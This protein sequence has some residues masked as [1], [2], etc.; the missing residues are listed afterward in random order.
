MEFEESESSLF[1]TAIEAIDKKD[2]DRARD[3]FTRLIKMNPEKADYWVWMSSLVPSVKEKTYCLQE[4]LRLD[5]RNSAARRGLA[6]LGVLSPDEKKIIPLKAQKRNWS[7]LYPSP[8]FFEKILLI[9]NWVQITVISVLGGSLLLFLLVFYL[10]TPGLGMPVKA[11]MI[12]RPVETQ[13]PTSYSDVSSLVSLNPEKTP[14]FLGPTPFSDLLIVTYTPTPIYVNTPHPKHEGYRSAINAFNK[15]DLDAAIDYLLQAIDA[16]PDSPDLYYHLGE[17][18]RLKKDY[19]NAINAYKKALTIDADFAPAYLGRG[20]ATLDGY[21]VKWKDAKADLIKATDLDSNLVEGYLKTAEI[22]LT[23][24]LDP[25]TAIKLIDKAHHSNPNDPQVYI[26][27]AKVYLIQNQPQK[28]LEEARVAF[29]LDISQLEAYHLVAEAAVKMDQPALALEELIFYCIYRPDDAEALYWLGLAY[30]QKG[31]LE[32][33]VA[34]YSKSIKTDPSLISTFLK[35][36]QIY[37]DQGQFRLARTD[38]EK[39]LSLDK[40]SYD[41]N[42]NMARVLLE[43]GEILAAYAK[44]NSADDLSVNNTQK[45]QIYYWRAKTL[46]KMEIDKPSYK[47]NEARDWLALLNQPP[48]TVPAEWVVEAQNRVQAIK[49]YTPLQ[50]TPVGVPEPVNTNVGVSNSGNR[51]SALPTAYQPVL[52]P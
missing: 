29:K 30:Q 6:M 16:D 35:R 10:T 42:F 44:F 9:P 1:Q 46:Q 49:G 7:N 25:D 4:A 28:A 12:G 32:K 45:T 27:Y 15:Q 18:Y 52:F 34:G 41:A 39:A 43:S 40:N 20:L 23:Y 13:T 14:T 50:A 48:E 11:T 8:G 22:T 47:E 24:N 37:I 31:D 3:L 5:A 26:E 2:K 51:A 38:F 21:P 33:A 36:G 17:A 19:S